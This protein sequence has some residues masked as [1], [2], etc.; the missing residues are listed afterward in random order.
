VD[1]PKALFERSRIVGFLAALGLAVALTPAMSPV[2][3]AP[4]SRAASYAN[5]AVMEWNQFA[6]AA[7]TTAGQGAVP[8]ARTMAIVQV[9]VHDAVNGITGAHG[10]YLDTG[11]APAGASPE[12]AAIAAA[13][14]ALVTLFP[15]QSAALDTSR[16]A[17][18][19]AL[20]LTED[21]PGIGWGENAAAGVLA[22][23]SIDGA[24]QASFPY[25]A[26][27]AGSPGVWVAIGT[28]PALLPGWGSVTPWVLRSGS[29]FRP[30][31]PPALDSGRYA[32]DYNEI[33]T[34]G[35]KTSS[36]RTFEQ[37]ETARFWLASPSAIWNAI[38]RRMIDAHDLDLSDAAH[39]FAL[40]YLAGADASIACWDAKYKFNFWR[41]QAAIQNG[42]SDGN[43][44]T[45]ADGTWEPLFPT[46]PHP[47]YLSGHATN[48]S[49]MATA[50][51]SVFGDAPGVPI[52]ATSPTNAAY[53]REWATFSEGVDEVI[54]ARIYSGIHFRTADEVGARVGGQVAR[55]VIHHALR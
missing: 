27:G 41:P 20:G 9:S 38:A 34:I 52:V 49:A 32:R 45:A 40:M 1:N 22:V 50:L 51:A 54:D 53:P 42:D 31:G 14:E 37:T 26:P 44:A 46:P 12:A 16:A 35:S 48:S 39:V 17:S 4:K 24:A 15:L 23:R 29:Q 28:T 21:D 18:L 5:D 8:Q 3:A 7:T 55:F 13:H 19:A 47:D 36:T 6:L 11:A 33:Q 30:D 43:D 2:H 25:T 10:T